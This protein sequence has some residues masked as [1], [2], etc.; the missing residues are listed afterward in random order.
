[1]REVSGT[2][3]EDEVP[4]LDRMGLTSFK[5]LKV[6]FYCRVWLVHCGQRDPTLDP[7]F[8]SERPCLCLGS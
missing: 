7:G 2:V 5:L 6:A 8:T 3:I 1:M 4:D